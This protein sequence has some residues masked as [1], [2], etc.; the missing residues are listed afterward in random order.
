MLV[1]VGASWVLGHMEKS[2]DLAKVPRV[3]GMGPV[4]SAGIIAYAA[5]KWFWKT[6]TARGIATGLLCVA[7]NRHGATGTIAG[8][9]MGDYPGGAVVF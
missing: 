5:S 7:A 4:A 6:P 8:D 9:V 3:L 1:P 2:G